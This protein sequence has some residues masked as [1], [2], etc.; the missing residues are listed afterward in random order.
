MALSYLLFL[1]MGVQWEGDTLKLDWRRFKQHGEPMF[2]GPL[3]SK[4]ESSKCSY[5]LIWFGQ[6]VTGIYNTW[7]DIPE[8]EINILRSFGESG[9]S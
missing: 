9:A 6:T 4:H 5:L 1:V 2:T 8:E 7:T 3:K